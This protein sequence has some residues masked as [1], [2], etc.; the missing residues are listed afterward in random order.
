MALELNESNFD[1]TISET[2]LPILIDLWASWCGPCR[3]LSPIID[4]LSKEYEDK[5]LICKV[6]VDDNSS[7]AEKYH[8]RSIPTILFIKNGQVSETLVGLSSKESLREKI[9]N[10]IK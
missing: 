8:I 9:E 6:N 5:L 1:K 4:E 2:N 3:Q 10:F 7:L